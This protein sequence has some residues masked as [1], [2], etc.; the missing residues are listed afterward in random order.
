MMAGQAR[1]PCGIGGLDENEIEHCLVERRP[2]IL[3]RQ[4]A[5]ELALVRL[6]DRLHGGIDQAAY[7]AFF[8]A[9]QFDGGRFRMGLKPSLLSLAC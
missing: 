7:I 4:H 2:C 3:F 9:G 8:V 6:F 5:P 1:S